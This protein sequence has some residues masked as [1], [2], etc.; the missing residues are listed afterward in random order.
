MTDENRLEKHMLYVGRRAI[1]KYGCSGCHD[2]P[3]FETAKPI[4]TGLAD[5]GRKKEA[6]LAFEHIHNYLEV[7]GVEEGD[8]S[9][10]EYHS[11]EHGGA[12]HHHDLDPRKYG[13]DTGYFLTGLLSGHRQ[14]FIWQK[15]RQPRSYDYKKTINKGYN[16]RL[17][18]P[19]FTFSLNEQENEA[20]REAIITFVLGLVSEPPRDQY[21]YQP[22]ARMKAI[23][24]GRKA[25]NKFNC[26][27][28][29]AMDVERWQTAYSEEDFRSPPAVVDFPFLSPHFTASEVEVTRR[30]QAWPPPRHAVRTP[31][32]RSGDRQ[33]CP[34]G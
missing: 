10:M 25:L 3:G 2:I 12:H 27:G 14:G 13:P 31:R 21:I 18:M 15:L 11:G 23:V 30:R 9:P 16:E 20:A 8:G 6:Q 17:R 24:E 33:P 32:A 29:H 1:S 7:H 22:D 34:T 19:K 26:A 28:C 5:W 4:G